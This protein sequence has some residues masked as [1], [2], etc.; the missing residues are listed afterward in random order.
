MSKNNLT[1]KLDTLSL[2]VIVRGRHRSL[3][4]EG[5]DARRALTPLPLGVRTVLIHSH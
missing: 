3:Y 2:T 1:S 5:T 4:R